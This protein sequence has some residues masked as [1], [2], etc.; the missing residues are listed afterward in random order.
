MCFVLFIFCIN[1]KI[2]NNIILFKIV[3]RF[4]LVLCLAKTYKLFNTL[5]LLVM[6]LLYFLKPGYIMLNSVIPLALLKCDVN[7]TG[8]IRSGILIEVINDFHVIVSFS[9]IFLLNS[10]S[11]RKFNNCWS[12]IR[13]T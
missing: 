6:I 2:N 1:H 8:F 5:L 13:I 11:Y 12:S 3:N 4:L 10:S 9:K 7:C